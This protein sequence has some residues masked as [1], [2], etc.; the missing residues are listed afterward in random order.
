MTPKQRLL[1]NRKR[2][3]DWYWNN[4]E[5][6]QN[7]FKKWYAKNRL[8]MIERSKQWREDNKER[9]SDNQAAWRKKVSS[10]RVI[11]AR[12]RRMDLLKARPSWANDFF[13]EEAYRLAE[14]RSKMLGYPWQVDHIVPLKSKKVCGLHVHNNLR[15]IPAIENNRK[16]NRHWPDMA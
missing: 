15:V 1:R 5:R 2:S 13:I 4:K 10:N 14:L 11:Q 6:V 3:R 12:K 8:L 16:G 9:Y 7:N